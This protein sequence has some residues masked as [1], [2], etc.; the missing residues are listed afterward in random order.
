VAA[1]GRGAN[2][3]YAGRQRLDTEPQRRGSTRGQ[4][5]GEAGG[6]SR[7]AITPTATPGAWLA[8]G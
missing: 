7:S 3:D 1:A 5:R 4:Q 2:N 8:G 6:V